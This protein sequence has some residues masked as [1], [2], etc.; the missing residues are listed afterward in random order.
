MM[1]SLVVIRGLECG[2]IAGITGRGGN[3]SLQNNGDQVASIVGAGILSGG[4]F[5]AMKI[6][7]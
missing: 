6:Q 4:Y 2:L 5:A 1:I 7:Y 3:G